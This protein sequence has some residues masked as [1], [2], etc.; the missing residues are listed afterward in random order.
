[1]QAGPLEEHLWFSEGGDGGRSLGVIEGPWGR[2]FTP[3]TKAEIEQAFKEPGSRGSVAIR[4]PDGSGHVFS[5]E[6]V[7]GQ[8]RF[9]DGQPTPPLT[10]VSHYFNEG[11]STAYVRL[12][13]LPTPPES[14]TKPYLEP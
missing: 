11:H 8:V 9:V 12:D 2:K 14:A 10:D 7:G 4:W 3:G 13:D 6:N 1:V 5:V